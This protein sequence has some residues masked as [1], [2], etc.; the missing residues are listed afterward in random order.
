[1]LDYVSIR[2]SITNY[3]Y[4]S[5]VNASDVNNGTVKREIKDDFLLKELFARKL[6]PTDED[7]MGAALGLLR[8]QITYKLDTFDIADGRIVSSGLKINSSALT[9]NV[10]IFILYGANG[11]SFIIKFYLHFLNVI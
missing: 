3:Y 2:I 5:I 10:M 4:W 9:G 1:M 11:C 6:L 7:A 8:L